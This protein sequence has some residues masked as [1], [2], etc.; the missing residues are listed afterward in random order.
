MESIRFISH[1]GMH[2]LVPG[3]IA[4]VFFREKWKLV[5]L[6]FISTMLVDLD[7]LIATP[8]FDKNRC[9]IGF[10]LLHSYIAIS[11]YCLLLVPK[12]TRVIAIGLLFHM[13]TDYSDCLY[14]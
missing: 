13:L 7:H 4:F 5:W 9:S 6:I 12:K 2:F 11:F 8:I 1:Y 3:I 10:H 14:I